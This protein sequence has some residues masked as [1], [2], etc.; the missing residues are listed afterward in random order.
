MNA[1]QELNLELIEKAS[2]NNFDGKLVVSELRKN[3]SLWTAVVMD[4][5]YYESA[6]K[7]G[8]CNLIKLRDLPDD[9]WNVDTV[10]IL[11][12]GKD[13]KLLMAVAKGWSADEISW[14]EGEKA[15]K[16]LGSFPAKQKILRAWWD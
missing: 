16:L 11:S 4:R 10:F 14:I 7:D 1:I 13:D 15:G 9:M 6:A 3:R 5:E 8:G 2:F 12:S